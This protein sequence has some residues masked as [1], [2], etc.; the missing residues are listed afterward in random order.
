MIIHIKIETGKEVNTTQQSSEVGF[1]SDGRSPVVFFVGVSV[2]R[3][4]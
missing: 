1:P 3:L 4:L 2:S